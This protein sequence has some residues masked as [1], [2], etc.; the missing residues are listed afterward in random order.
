MAS[1]KTRTRYKW[2]GIASVVAS[3]GA[4]VAFLVFWKQQAWLGLAG[5][6]GLISGAEMVGNTNSPD[7]ASLTRQNII[8]GVLYAAAA[9]ATFF[10]LLR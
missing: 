10:L 4:A 9:I 5:L 6:V 7:P 3:V 1:V 2:I 8:F